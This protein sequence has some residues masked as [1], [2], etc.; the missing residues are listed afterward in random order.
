MTS[1]DQRI[2]IF[3]DIIEELRV[4]VN[5]DNNLYPE[6]WLTIVSKIQGNIPERLPRNQL[7]WA[8]KKIIVPLPSL[9]RDTHFPFLTFSIT[10]NGDNFCC[11]I[12]VLMLKILGD[13]MVGIGFRME[14]PERCFGSPNQNGET[15]THDF[16]HAQLVRDIR[17]W[18][19]YSTPD[20]LPDSVPSFPLW[21]VEPVDLLL[22]MILTLYGARCYS[23]FWKDHASHVI[24]AVSQE[25]KDFTKNLLNR[26]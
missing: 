22:N 5:N 17:G 6:D 13:K 23:R 12:Y 25:F 19:F 3:F 16:C 10:N 14:S 1:V 7:D 2:Q 24:P 8:G 26:K 9:E 15:G 4:K 20:Y 21:A 11:R 18:N